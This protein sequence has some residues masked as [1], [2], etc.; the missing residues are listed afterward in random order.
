MQKRVRRRFSASLRDVQTPSLGDLQ[1]DSYE[2]LLQIK[3]DHQSREDVGLERI[4]RSVFPISDF[5]QKIT[6]EYLWYQLQTSKYDVE[7]CCH[8]G[9]TYSASIMVRLRLSF[10]DI[11]EKTGERTLRNVKEQD[12]YMGEVPLM[13][14]EGTF[15]INGIERVI[16]SQVHVS[17]GVFFGHDGGRT[18]A[19]D[20]LLYSARVIPYRGSWMD[21]EFDHRDLLFIRVD[22]RRKLLATTFLMVL[23][24]ENDS[25]SIE[26][27]DLD[28][29]D[30]SGM[31]RS[32]ILKT[33]Y[34]TVEY[35]KEGDGWL[36][37]LDPDV[38]Y[39]RVFE[40][41]LYDRDKNL[42]VAKGVKIFPRSL[43]LLKEAEGKF[44]ANDS[45][46]VGLY[47]AEDVHLGDNEHGLKAGDPITEEALEKIAAS[48]IKKLNLLVRDDAR[49]GWHLRNTVMEDSNFS[50]E[51]ALCDIY[52]VLRPG[53]PPTLE[54]AD[55]FVKTLFF[56][57]GH[58]DLSAVGRVKMNERLGF[59]HAEN[60]FVLRKKDII[61]ML[62]VLIALRDGEGDV[63]DIDNLSNRRVR[64]VGELLENQYRAS[65]LHMDRSVR[66]RMGTLKADIMPH[67]LINA[68]LVSSST[69]EF[70]T[71]SQLS[72]F[73]DQ[74]NPLAEVT[75]KRR[76][77]AL[78]PGGLSRERATFEVRDVHPT[79]YGRICPIE[80]PEGPNIGLINS[81][82]TYGRVNRYG[83]IETPYFVVKDGA[84]LDEII[85]YTAF[86]EHV[87]TI[88]Q[89]GTPTDSEGRITVEYVSC[90]RASEY[91]IV[92]VLEVT[93]MDT[94]VLQPVSLAASLIPFLE[95]DDAN[96]ALMG[97]NMQ[98]QAVPLLCAQAP[99][100]GTGIEE[101]VVRQSGAAVLAKRSGI[102]DYVDAVRIVVR[103]SS[104]DDGAGIDI[105]DLKKFSR[106]NQ[107]TCINQRPNV[108][109]GDVVDAGDVLA[110]GHATNR[111]ELALGD[112]LLIGFLS[113]R[114]YNFEDSIMV[115]ESLLH[116][117]VFTSIHIEEFEVVT[118]DTKIGMEEI[119]R[120]IPHVSDHSLRHLDSTGVVCVGSYVEPGDV[121]IGK[122][123]PRGETTMTAEDRLLQ[124]VFGDKMDGVRD[125]SLR[126]PSGV[127]GTV[128]DVRL[129][130]RRGVEK[131]DKALLIEG[132][133][134]QRLQTELKEA[135]E[136]L[137]SGYRQYLLHV[138]DGQV[139][140]KGAKSSAGSFESGV[141]LTKENLSICS[142][143]QLK[144]FVVEDSAVMEKV[145]KAMRAYEKHVQKIEGIFHEKIDK[146]CIGDDLPP[147]V[148]KMV[149]V[150]VAIKRKVQIGDKLAGRHGN[151]GVI[152]QITPVE[153]MPY[154]ED[155][156]PLDMILN[157]LGIPSRMNIGQVLETHLGWAAKGLGEKIDKMVVQARAQAEKAL[158]LRDFLKEVFEQQQY[159]HFSKMSDEELLQVMS[160]ERALSMAVPVFARVGSEAIAEL[161]DKG[162]CDQS[163]QEFLYDGCTGDRFERKVTVGYMYMMKLHHLVDEKIHARSVGPYS[164]VT[165]QPLGGKAQ[166]GGQRFGEMEVWA[167]EAYGAAYTLREMLTTKSD[168]VSGRL[169]AYEAIVR[170][171]QDFQT[172]L[173]ESFKVLVKEVRAL[174]IN[175]EL[176]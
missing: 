141:K 61:E 169:Q 117:D 133:E 33:F 152:S 60:P 17:P 160:E 124:A 112:N 59:D 172:H 105:Y 173:P 23:E 130:S 90:R 71:S 82:A 63:D 155:G 132:V 35:S 88:A 20:K 3:V 138:F 174:G 114:G 154:L 104:D 67:D 166:F 163:G 48:G 24:S 150:F 108:R 40:H 101:E 74:T 98:R 120:D 93:L 70:F 51:D 144:Q 49:Y 91:V 10:F 85:Y 164:L 6:L 119:T 18:S 147:G 145:K 2:R 151:K 55:Q 66:E 106:S 76:L 135:R 111:G 156:R 161:L 80:T 125:T 26:D 159:E 16:I 38:W 29:G 78:G 65:L 79:H 176:K 31:S 137:Q 50:R 157:P 14:E 175:M 129:F 8:R 36:Y 97:S 123:T 122:V 171:G 53:E 168:D 73:M 107:S 46:I 96:R 140:V 28:E 56:H 69:P 58:Y 7:E 52:S 134:V 34:K 139:F 110:D 100:V 127:C 165:Q 149:K 126:M 12:V 1:K 64:C 115:S 118:R 81:L 89:A 15:I 136:S 9:L 21:V 54:G 72:Q 143:M 103:A 44:W 99:I 92:H 13:T 41:A 142:F 148:S 84:V 32:E 95:N 153:D 116:R 162:D 102:V 42:L 37:E 146:V 87:E 5:S 47:V 128:V 83:F 109:V 131:D 25:K 27:V 57:E 11:D 75:H 86:G 113:W 39:K 167:L 19:S 94:S 45:D 68:K 77:S 158:V 22:R 4:L 62:R 30:I 121:L 43:K 170:G